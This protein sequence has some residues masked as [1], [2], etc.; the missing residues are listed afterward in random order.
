M[1]VLDIGFDVM[2]VGA[3][4]YLLVFVSDISDVDPAYLTLFDTTVPRK[5]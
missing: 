2:I 5:S 3:Y 4:V 1:L